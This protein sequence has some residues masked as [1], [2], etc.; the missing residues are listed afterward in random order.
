MGIL[1]HDV[2]K[3]KKHVEAGLYT[4]P[5]AA[6]H[7]PITSIKGQTMGVNIGGAG[8][9]A[10]VGES[11]SGGGSW[12]MGNWLGSIDTMWFYV[13]GVSVGGLMLLG[14]LFYVAVKLNKVAPYRRNTARWEEVE[15]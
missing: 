5:L 2:W 12:N 13:A 3:L 6:P 14:L 15:E 7:A 9:G 8:N 4:V 10:S 1:D 11:S